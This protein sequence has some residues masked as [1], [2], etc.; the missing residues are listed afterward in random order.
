MEIIRQAVS[1]QAS[2]MRSISMKGPQRGKQVE[3]PSFDNIMQNALLF[4][5]EMK[6]SKMGVTIFTFG[7]QL[8]NGGWYTRI[9]VVQQILSHYLNVITCC[10]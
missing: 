4:K 6:I 2:V 5:I 9:D 8:I 10:M 7:N 1:N 3:R